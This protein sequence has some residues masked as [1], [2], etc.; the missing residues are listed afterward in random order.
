MD[1]ITSSFLNVGISSGE[2]E[3]QNLKKALYDICNTPSCDYD[4]IIYSIANRINYY[5]VSINFNPEIYEQEYRLIISEL[6]EL[7]SIF[8]NTSDEKV[9]EK[10]FIAERIFSR[11][12]FIV[13]LYYNI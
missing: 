1:D 3:Y 10:I 8:F 5:H 6:R 9:K 4:K 12:F 2:T 11:M 7:Y 13:Q